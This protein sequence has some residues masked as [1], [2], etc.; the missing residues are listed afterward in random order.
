MNIQLLTDPVNEMENNTIYIDGAYR[1]YAAKPET[2]SFSFDHHGEGERF[3]LSATCLQVL[4]AL[5]LGLRQFLPDIEEM[6][7]SSID[8]DSILSTWLVLNPAA[9]DDPQFANFVREVSQIDANGAS[10]ADNVEGLSIFGWARP[11]RGV[12]PSTEILLSLVER[13]GK[14]YTEGTLYRRDKLHKFKGTAI[15]LSPKGEIVF[16]RDGENNFA[17]I[18]KSAGFGFLLGDKITIGKL[19]FSKVPSLKSL[20]PFLSEQFQ[21]GNWGGADTIGGS[22]FA[23]T[24][25]IPSPEELSKAIKEWLASN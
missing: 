4:N 10:A 16:S 7:V 25:A 22:P 5:R 18:Y 3:P 14:E 1:G 19:P 9:A 8:A 12:V 24:G 21:I 20:W 6:R 13:V 15:G 2:N 17:D 23:P 11:E